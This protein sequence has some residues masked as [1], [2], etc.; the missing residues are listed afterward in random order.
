[1][2]QMKV[3]LARVRESAEVRIGAVCKRADGAEA[4]AVTLGT[5]LAAI[6]KGAVVAAVARQ[7]AAAEADSRYTAL[8]VHFRELTSARTRIDVQRCSA[9]TF[10]IM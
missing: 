6:Y 3:E 7:R 8:Q 1:M 9:I 10:G 5:G 2:E 4:V